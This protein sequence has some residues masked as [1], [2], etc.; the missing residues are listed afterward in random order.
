MNATYQT[1]DIKNRTTAGIPSGVSLAPGPY[2]KKDGSYEFFENANSFIEFPSSP[3]GA[4]DVRY[5]MTILCWVYYDQKGGP[6]G[7][8]FNYFQGD[9]WGVHLWVL[10]RLLFA[11]FVNRVFS[12]E[13]HTALHDSSLAGGW[14]FVGASYDY[15]T[16]EIKLW[17]DGALKQA[18]NI[19]PHKE[20]GTQGSVR[21]GVRKKDSRFF[22][23]RISQL[24]IYN[25]ALSQQQ[26][27]KLA[28]EP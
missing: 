5:S 25:K 18:G 6:S 11:R 17:V 28:T 21:M 27:L 13:L 20:L 9:K 23:G 3:G 7:P 22:K 26:I 19:G 2:G 4:L 16:G 12:L 15:E 1:S 14:K 24:Q 8:I 10:D